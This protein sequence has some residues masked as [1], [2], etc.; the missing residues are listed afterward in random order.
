[1]GHR[2]AL[3]FGVKGNRA[4]SKFSKTIRSERTMS[5]DILLWPIL[6]VSLDTILA[7]SQGEY[8]DNSYLICSNLVLHDRTLG[9]RDAVRHAHA[10]ARASAWRR[11]CGINYV[12]A[13][14]RTT[15]LPTPPM[16]ATLLAALLFTVALL[17]TT[18]YFLM[19][20]VPL[21]ILKHDS[22]MDSRFV[23]SFFNIYYLL[24]MCTASAAAVSYALAERPPLA[25][26]AVALA[27]LAAILRRNVIPKMDA[28]RAEIHT[29][30]ASTIAAFRRIHIAAITINLAQLAIIVWTLISVSISLR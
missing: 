14:R 3:R 28:L 21:L 16:S 23:R 12:L 1:M 4:G 24:M 22:P 13:A 10:G 7:S 19:G 6:R 5:N 8:Y 29:S 27:L 17:A 25:I 20:S 11:F 18:T 2:R 30:A 9:H 26:G 15:Q